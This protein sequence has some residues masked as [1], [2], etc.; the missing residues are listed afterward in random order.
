MSSP[1]L[2][3]S[4][5]SASS[6]LSYLTPPRPPPPPPP[7]LMVRHG[8]ARW[9]TDLDDEL[10][11]FDDD[12][13]VQGQG[14]AAAA[15]G[16]IG[17]GGVEAVNAAAAPRQG[18][19]H[20]GHPPLPRPPPRQCPRCGSANTKFCYYNNYSRTQPRYLCKACRRHW[21]EGGT[22]RD[23]PVG[24]GRKNSKRAAGGGKA[25][26]TASTAASAHVVAP[27]AA[28][29]TSSS[30]PDLLRQMLMAP[31]TAGGGGGYSIDLTAWQQMAAFAAP[32]QAA[33][34]DVGGAVGAASTAAPDANCGGG[35]VQYWNGWLQDDMPGLD[36][37]C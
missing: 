5:S 12:L 11:V 1:F 31:A 10:M 2:G 19:R 3:S 23:V 28:P 32:P 25:G 30:F 24:G 18:G 9:L 14:Y 21:T 27:A 16:G 17:G 37:S 26:A 7:L 36:G 22:L 20:A 4:S 15:N 6:P 13:G 29:P 33:T 35:G 34:G 8:L